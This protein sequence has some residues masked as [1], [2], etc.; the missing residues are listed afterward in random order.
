M[1]T[2]TESWPAAVVGAVLGLAAAVVGAVLG[3]AVVGLVC[4]FR[5]LLG[6]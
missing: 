4:V 3:L 5:A 2:T 6:G 1:N